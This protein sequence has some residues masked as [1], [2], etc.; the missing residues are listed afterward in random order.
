MIR[1][2]S[3]KLY[4]QRTVLAGGYGRPA[5]C[6]MQARFLGKCKQSILVRTTSYGTRIKQQSYLSLRV[7]TVF[8]LGFTRVNCQRWKSTWTMKWS[9]AYSLQAL[10]QTKRI[11]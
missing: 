7:F 1:L 3:M 5:I 2:L 9:S 11:N 10:S 6:C 4:V 8:H